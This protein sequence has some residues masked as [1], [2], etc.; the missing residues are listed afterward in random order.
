L[1]ETDLLR[2]ICKQT[3]GVDFVSL[4]CISAVWETSSN[5]EKMEVIGESVMEVG[6]KENRGAKT[7]TGSAEWGRLK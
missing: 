3:E 2:L 7:G 4:I 5:I 6:S 1:S